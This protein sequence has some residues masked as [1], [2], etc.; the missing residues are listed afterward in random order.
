MV[1]CLVKTLIHEVSPSLTM[2]LISNPNFAIDFRSPTT[3]STSQ[4]YTLI[5]IIRLVTYSNESI[6]QWL[7]LGPWHSKS[8]FNRLILNFAF[9][10]PTYGEAHPIL[11]ALCKTHTSLYVHLQ[12]NFASGPKENAKKPKFQIFHS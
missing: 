1:T 3:P 7:H 10:F 6:T 12:Y 11:V 2:E 8:R 5:I 4:S 9:A